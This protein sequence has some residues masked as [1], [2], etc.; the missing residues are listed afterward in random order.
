MFKVI[1]YAETVGGDELRIPLSEIN[2]KIEILNSIFNE[3]LY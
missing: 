1:A 3:K 2:N